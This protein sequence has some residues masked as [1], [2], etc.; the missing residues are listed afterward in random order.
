MGIRFRRSVKLAPGLRWNVGQ[1]STSV[2]VGPPGAKLTVGSRGSRVTAGL[3][4]TGLSATR[5]LSQHSAR[6]RPIFLKIAAAFAAVWIVAAIAGVYQ[7]ST[8]TIVAG[9]FAGVTA[10]VLLRIFTRTRTATAEVRPCP[11][12]D[13]QIP[14]DAYFCRHCNQN[15]PTNGAG[16]PVGS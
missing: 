14:A 7:I 10:V 4:G 6:T 12:C 2:S 5:S 3:P 8:L 9:A 16:A 13:Q 15:L 1:R 11:L